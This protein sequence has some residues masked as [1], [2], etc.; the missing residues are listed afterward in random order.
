MPIPKP[1]PQETA[2]KFMQ[3]CMADDVM[4]QEYPNTKQRAAIC[5]VQWRDSDN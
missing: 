1:Q 4:V 5:A 2:P 3:R